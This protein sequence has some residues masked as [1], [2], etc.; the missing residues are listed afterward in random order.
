MTLKI[1]LARGGSKKRPYYHVVVADARAPRDGRFLEKLGSWNPMLPKDNEKRVELN[2]ERIQEW[3][4]KGAQPTDRVLRFL[5]EAGVAQRDARNN[6]EK[7]KPGKKAQERA[8]ERAQREEDA[9]AAA[10]EAAAE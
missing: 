10:A 8:A 6:P 3:I 2:L 5:A 1:R 7:A 9:K 4:A